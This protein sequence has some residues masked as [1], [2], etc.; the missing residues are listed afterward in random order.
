[1]TEMGV[2]IS[3]ANTSPSTPVM[4]QLMAR[5]RPICPDMAPSVM[6]K[7]SPM[8]AKI[9][10]I[11]ASTRK[12]L[13]PSLVIISWRM[14]WIESPEGGIAANVTTTKMMTTAFSLEEAAEFLVA[15]HFATFTFRVSA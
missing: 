12:V 15:A 1:M 9:G 5:M 3:A 8:P 7:L 14:Y 6:P 10:R 11:R 2:P 13:R 4:F